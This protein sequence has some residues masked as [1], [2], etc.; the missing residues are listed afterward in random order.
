MMQFDELK[1]ML[2]IGIIEPSDSSWSVPIVL[3]KNTERSL[4]L[5]ICLDY[6]HLNGETKSDAH[7][8]PCIN[9][10]ID[11][12]GRAKHTSHSWLLATF[13]NEHGRRQP[14]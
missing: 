2:A 12:L 7:L 13:A 1:S 5:C 8:M 6:R 9:A 3:V 10:L 14:D 4:R 11:Q